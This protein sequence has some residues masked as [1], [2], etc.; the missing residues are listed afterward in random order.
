MGCEED[1]EICRLNTIEEPTFH[2]PSRFWGQ[3]YLSEPVVYALACLPMRNMY[4]EA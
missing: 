3:Y 1:E 4:L 2:M